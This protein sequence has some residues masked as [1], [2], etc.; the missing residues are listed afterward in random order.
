MEKP[1]GQKSINYVVFY[2]E[3]KQKSDINANIVFLSYFSRKRNSKD[4]S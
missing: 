1:T 3:P 4:K 2:P